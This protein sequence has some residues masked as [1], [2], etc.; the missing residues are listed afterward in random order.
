MKKTYITPNARIISLNTEEGTLRTG[1]IE[2]HG[3]TNTGENLSGSGTDET[4]DG[5]FDSNRRYGF[6]GGMWDNM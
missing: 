6:G 3:S 1:S 5:E 4:W 2:D